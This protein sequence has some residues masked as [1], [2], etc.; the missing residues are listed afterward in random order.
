[1]PGT[2]LEADVAIDA[3]L[4][5]PQTAVQAVARRVRLRD[6]G[7][8]HSH[9]LRAQDREQLPVEARAEPAAAA[10]LIQIDGDVGRPPVGGALAV[11][12][13]VRVADDSAVVLRDEPGVG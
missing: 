12:R 5:E 3:D 4:L 1:M 11:W 9:A 7:A 10:I 6:A 13:A 8:E 2:V